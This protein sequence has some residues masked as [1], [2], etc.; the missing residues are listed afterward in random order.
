MRAAAPAPKAAPALPV[1]YS[2]TPDLA[3][4]QKIADQ[5]NLEEAA[6]RCEKLLEREK[7]DPMT[8][9]YYAL[10]LEQM[11]RRRETQESLRRA[12]YLDRNFIVAHY[13]LGLIQQRLAEPKEA[14][15]CFRNALNLLSGLNADQSI[16]AADE[17]SVAELKH[18]IQM[19][20]DALPKV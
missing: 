13:Y 1:N 5:G 17:Y 16:P 7:L 9:F 8:H 12:I 15:R 6:R 4:I 18:L 2:P 19:H 14:S 10:I 3:A 20:I 11:G